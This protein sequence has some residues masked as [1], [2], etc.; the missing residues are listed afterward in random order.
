[1][2]ATAPHVYGCVRRGSR[3]SAAVGRRVVRKLQIGR[4]LLPGGA[5]RTPSRLR[6][7]CTQKYLAFSPPQE[8]AR[9]LG[10]A[11]PTDWCAAVAL[12][13]TG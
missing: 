9:P 13:A 5:A 12:T 11:P 8:F 3:A 2:S 7:H 4:L 1:M 6:S 10:V